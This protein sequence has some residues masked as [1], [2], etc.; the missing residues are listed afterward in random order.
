MADETNETKC[1]H[2]SC[3]C[4]V[5]GAQRYCSHHCEDVADTD[6]T[7]PCTC[8]HPGCKPT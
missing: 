7:S 2:Q 4:M 3:T 1:A 5:S 8:N 6:P